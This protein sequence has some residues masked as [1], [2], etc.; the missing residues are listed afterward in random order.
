MSAY[1]VLLV[2]LVALGLLVGARL[3]R[4]FAARRRA[5]AFASV[6]S[7]SG[8]ADA[9]QELVGCPGRLPSAEVDRIRHRLRALVLHLS[10]T[11][12]ALV[13]LGCGPSY[14]PVTTTAKLARA[15]CEPAEAWEPCLQK[16]HA[17]SAL[18]SG[19]P[20]PSFREVFM[21]TRD[22][23]APTIDMVQKFAPGLFSRHDVDPERARKGGELPRAFLLEALELA[24]FREPGLH[25][26]LAL[27]VERAAR[28]PEKKRRPRVE[29]VKPAEVDPATVATHPPPTPPPPAPSSSTT[30]PLFDTE[31]PTDPTA[32]D[33]GGM[34]AE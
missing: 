19:A 5:A 2:A 33:P 34:D 20:T 12:L 10:C 30:V 4:H 27:D 14:P 29:P 26:M 23:L 17:A 9:V 11:A 15:V 13:A 21:L 28:E 1:I 22:I 3:E 31:P 7:G 16:A 6:F 32:P 8:G 25:G 18:D 24:K